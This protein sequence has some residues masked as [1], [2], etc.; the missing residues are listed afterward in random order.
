M[1]VLL[2]L[3]PKEESGCVRWQLQLVA[4]GRHPFS[5]TS[6]CHWLSFH[7]THTPGSSK[8]SKFACWFLPVLTVHASFID[9]GFIVSCSLNS[10]TRPDLLARNHLNNLCLR[11]KTKNTT[12][13]TVFE[14]IGNQDVPLSSKSQKTEN[15]WPSSLLKK[16]K[17]LLTKSKT[18]TYLQLQG[19]TA[20][21][22]C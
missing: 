21:S 19:V 13:R 4:K 5:Y 10:K 22:S 15:L 17:L 1:W 12:W 14:L 6:A 16:M 9:M 7:P 2:W 20:A 3:P 8:S 11:R 18:E